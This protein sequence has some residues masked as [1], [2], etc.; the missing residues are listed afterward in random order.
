MER[1]TEPLFGVEQAGVAVVPG[2]ALTGAEGVA[3]RGQHGVDGGE[4]L[5]GADEQRRAVLV[6]QH[7]GGLGGELEGVGVRV[8]HDEAVG[9][10]RA[11]PLA[12][13]ALVDAGAFGERG[14]GQWPGTRQCL[15][16]AEL[17]AEHDERSVERGSGLPGDMAGESLQ[18]GRVGNWLMNR[19]CHTAEQALAHHD[20]AGAQRLDTERDGLIAELRAA[21]GLGGRSRRLGSE[22]ERARKT[23]T[24]RIRNTL[25]RI[26]ERHPALAEHLHTS[27]TTGATCRYQ[28]HEPAHWTT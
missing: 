10:L 28:P 24:A 15:P 1:A 3:E 25:S 14:Q 17:V 27:V 13:V 20:D 12:Q 22:T 2:D 18:R 19:S 16:E 4:E 8:V 5:E 11:G 23:V 6:S 7:G 9:D 21:T 26:D